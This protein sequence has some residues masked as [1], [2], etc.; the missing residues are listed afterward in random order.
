MSSFSIVAGDKITHK[1]ISEAIQLDRLSYD[2]IYQL[3]VDT[4][5][6][7]YARNHDI[8]IMAVDNETGQVVGYI[9]FSPI[10]ELVYSALVSGSVVDTVIVGDDVL[11]YESGNYYWGYFSSI[12]VHPEYRRQGIATQMLLHWTDLVL[13]L[14]TIRSIFFQGIVADAVS[15]VGAYLLSEIGFSFSRPSMHDSTIMSVNLFSDNLVPSQFNEKILDVYKAHKER[16]GTI[17][18]I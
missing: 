16:A 13:R 17:N 18:G 14:A 6:E 10:R 11:P 1:M 4:C 3:Q 5:F 9:N 12:V 7:Y 8:Y 2:D 15:D